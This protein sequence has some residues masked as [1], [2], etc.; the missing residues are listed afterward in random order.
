MGGTRRVIHPRKKRS[1]KSEKERN[2]AKAFS[3]FYENPF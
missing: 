1:V 2:M 3:N